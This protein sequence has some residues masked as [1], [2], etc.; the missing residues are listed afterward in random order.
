L[1]GSSGHRKTETPRRDV[2]EK[3]HRA[4]LVLMAD[5]IT[6]F[7][8]FENWRDERNF[9]ALLLFQA[10]AASKTKG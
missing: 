9:A 4:D 5:K 7:I 8:P 10:G 3:L 1:G 6:G 2:V